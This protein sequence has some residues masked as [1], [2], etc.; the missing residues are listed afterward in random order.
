MWMGSAPKV[1]TRCQC[2]EGKGWSGEHR[3][4]PPAGTRSEPW[5]QMYLVHFQQSRLLPVPPGDAPD[6]KVI[7][8]VKK[9]IPANS[10]G[11]SDH[12]GNWPN[13]CSSSGSINVWLAFTLSAL[14]NIASWPKPTVNTLSL[15]GA[16]PGW[17]SSSEK[18]GSSWAAATTLS[19]SSGRRTW[20]H[21]GQPVSFDVYNRFLYDFIGSMTQFVVTKIGPG[22][23]GNSSFCIC[24][25]PPKWP[26]RCCKM[27]INHVTLHCVSNNVTT[28]ASCSFD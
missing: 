24:H 27:H 14:D 2:P 18:P 9:L 10:T 13:E 23:L 25:G 5:A 3:E 28:V 1:L 4:L 22:K 15:R 6:R 7:S 17:Q 16:F 26:A 8:P 12:C 11:S 21:P 19:A 20:W